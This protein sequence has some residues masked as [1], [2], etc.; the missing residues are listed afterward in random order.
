VPAGSLYYWMERLA[1]SGVPV[2]GVE[3]RFG[4]RALTLTDPHGLPLALVETSDPREYAPWDRSPV[5]AE[6]QVM[7]L[8]GA[9]LQERE[10]APTAAFLVDVLGFTAI[11]EDRGWRRFGVHG[12]GSGRHVDVLVTPDAP[13][14]AWGTGAVHHVAWRVAD[15]AA[16]LAVRARVAAAHRRPTPVIDRF[17]FRSVYFMEPGGAL[18]EIA[19]DGPGFTADEDLATLGEQLIL[20]PWLEE[21]RGEIEG[22]LPPLRY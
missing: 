9:R 4:E 10:L 8:H 2:G 22:A 16:E 13:R 21:R 3:E 18:F 11:G 17:W 12:G 6:W 14:G 15:D 5:P 7:G 20:P 19:T 1:R